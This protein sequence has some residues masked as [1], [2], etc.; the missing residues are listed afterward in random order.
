MGFTKGV[1]NSI[2]VFTQGNTFLDFYIEACKTI[3]LEHPGQPSFMEVGT[4]FLS[5]LY[6]VLPFN[7]IQENA[8]FSP[9]IMQGILTENKKY[10][11]S[12]MEKQTSPLYAANLCS[13][14]IVKNIFSKYRNKEVRMTDELY[15]QV[16]NKLVDS[17]GKILEQYK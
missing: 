8:L 16:I 5:A 15:L 13:S 11:Q 2:S 7:L 9:I 12:F 4:K 1:N 17:K 3:I 6:L 10:L 14:L